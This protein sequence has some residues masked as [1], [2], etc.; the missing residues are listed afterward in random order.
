MNAKVLAEWEGGTGERVVR[1]E[2]SYWC[3][4][5]PRS[6]QAFPYHWLIQP[7]EEEIGELLRRTRA[8][9]VRYS[10]P[11]E[12]PV[13][14]LSYHVVCENKDYS[15]DD[16][17]KWS[18]R[19][20]KRCLRRA[21][22]EPISFERLAEEG[23]TL[24]RET[25][26]RQGRRLAT[27]SRSYWRRLC[28]AAG[29]LPGFCAWGV[30]MGDKLAASLITFQIDDC[31][32]M[33]YQMS[34]SDFLKDYV[35]KALAFVV[36][37]TMLTRPEV[38]RV[39]YGLHGL[40]APDSVD[41][42]KFRMGYVAKPVR[43][44]IVLA[45]SVRWLARPPLH[46]FLKRLLKVGRSSHYVK[47]Y[48]GKVE[49]MVRWYLEGNRPLERQPRPRPLANLALP[50]SDQCGAGGASRQSSGQSGVVVAK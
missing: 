8:V 27:A 42:F 49:G 26:H 32:Y 46:A 5:G 6:Y 33:M 7:S 34:L 20:I 47:H 18:R 44:R 14:R 28:L 15:L 30:L 13:G 12:A 37:Q 43:Q 11:L 19:D 31:A 38:K 4:Q 39:F 45:P 21:S 35:N 25:L 16:L 50:G 3:D 2:H 48:V 23:W 10:A 17:D 9:C 24:R 40:D 1:T 22:V 29:G 36:T 41:E